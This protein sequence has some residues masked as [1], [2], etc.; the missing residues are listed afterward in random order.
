MNPPAPA[1]LAAH[2]AATIA[3]YPGDAFLDGRMLETLTLHREGSL[4]VAW[5]PFD[6][7]ASNARLAVVG[8]TPGRQ[9]AENAL[10]AFQRA[11]SAG[12]A[13]TEALRRAKLVGA[14][15]GPMRSNLV[16][17]LD[18]IGVPAALGVNS[19]K[20]LFE[21]DRHLA[22]LTSALR[23][24]VFVNGQNYNGTPDML[25]TPFLRHMVETHLAEEAAAL[26]RALW[27]PLGP[28]PAM[29]LQHLASLGLIDRSRILDGVPHPSGA[30]GE[31]VAYFLGRKAR[32]EI[33]G[34]TRPGPIDEARERLIFQVSRFNAGTHG[35]A[36]S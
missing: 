14:F 31:R 24:P 25:R 30:N 13:H 35:D 33:S 21:P 26:P 3:T 34:K 18:R 15:S 36:R 11:L 19:A 8:I 17:M 4:A 29:A 5:A 22:H 23:Y 12:V 10:S 7:V 2:F 20:E 9:Q 28:K 6:D 16:A 27:L 1:N 32:H